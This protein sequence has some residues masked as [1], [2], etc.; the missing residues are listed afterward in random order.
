MSSIISKS[1]MCTY[2]L[3]TGLSTVSPRMNLITL[4]MKAASVAGVSMF[5]FPCEYDAAR[6]FAAKGAENG[7]LI[8]DPT[9]QQVIKE[10]LDEMKPDLP[11]IVRPEKSANATK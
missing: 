9:Y 5:G 6:V 2:V 1:E 7:T 8:S 11:L 3:G 4:S 10:K